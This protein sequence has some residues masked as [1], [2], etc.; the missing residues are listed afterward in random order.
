MSQTRSHTVARSTLGTAIAL[1][2]CIAGVTVPFSTAD[3]AGPNRAGVVVDLAN[4]TVTTVPI[5]FSGAISGI[6]ALQQ[7]GFAPAVRSFGGLGG[8]VC[9][10]NVGGTQLGCPTDASCLTCA[11]PKYWVYFRA[12]AGSTTFSMSRGGA[13]ATALHDGDIEGWRWQSGNTPPPYVSINTLFPPATTTRPTTPTTKPPTTTPSTR[14]TNTSTS[15]STQTNG[16]TRPSTGTQSPP[17][18]TTTA[19]PATPPNGVPATSGYAITSTSDPS[20]I[21]RS[22][23][24][25]TG[26]NPSDDPPSTSRRDSAV[27]EP[28]AAGPPSVGPTKADSTSLLPA[29][30]ALIA[31]ALLVTAIV[32][33]RIRRNHLASQ[34]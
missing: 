33:L 10:L 5:T 22:N 8:A 9:A 2:I 25:R 32:A 28:R 13:G 7:A 6:E 14:P 11:A 29:V 3:A 21:T 23:G 15:T 27:G 1:L 20:P 26:A 17:S 16:T 31:I 34:I 4:G 24:V 19:N 30:F 12:P 18:S